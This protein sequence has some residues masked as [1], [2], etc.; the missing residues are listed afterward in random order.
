M[1]QTA[2]RLAAALADRYRLERE[3]GAGGM[4]TVYLAQDLKHDRQVAIK[5]LKPELAAVLGAERFVVEIKTTAALQHPHILPLFDSGTATSHPE[6][7]EGSPAASFLY[8]VMPYIEGETLRD[9]LSRETQLGVDEAVRITTQVADALDYAHR[10]G[11]IHRDIKPENILLHDGRPMVADFGIAL[12]VSAAAGGRMT[13][14]GLSLGTPHYMSPEQA[15][16]DKQITARS[17]IYSLASVL[18]EMLAGEPPHMGNSAQAITMK[19]IAEPAGPVT[20]HRKSV[21]PNVA[22]AIAKAL[23][24]LPA[25]RFDSARQF[26]EALGNT[27]FTAGVGARTRE[28]ATSRAWSRQT[29]VAAVAVVAIVLGAWGWLRPAPT[30][31]VRRYAM[32]LPRDQQLGGWFRRYAISPD[33]STIAYLHSGPGGERQLMVMPRDQLQ[34]TQLA[35]TGGAEVPFFSPDGR[36]IGFISPRG[37]IKVVATTG[38]QVTPIAT[39]GVGYAGATWSRNGYIYAHGLPGHGLVR[40][41]ATGGAVTPFTTIDTAAGETDHIMPVALPRGGGILFVIKHHDLSKSVVA[42]A[43]AES[44]KYRPVTNGHYAEYVQGHLVFQRDRF[45][46]LVIQPFDEGRMTISGEPRVLAPEVTM[47]AVGAP[48]FI[49]EFSVSREG[50]LLYTIGSGVR[51]TTDVV[52]VA[53]D[54]RV[55]PLD[56]T[57]TDQLT[58]NGAFALSP[59]GRRLAV[60]RGGQIWIRDLESR[61]MT[62][63]SFEGG[64]RPVWTPTGDAVAYLSDRTPNLREP[65]MRGADAREPER[66]LL[67]DPRQVHEV[68]FSRDGRW[69]VYRD[70]GGGTSDLL[71]VRRGGDTTRVPLITTPFSE[72]QPALSPDTR[73]L[74]YTTLET[75]RPQVRVRP[76]PNTRDGNWLVSPNG[77]SEPVWAHSGREL[78]YRDGDDNLV[79]VPVTLGPTFVF[80]APRILFSAKQYASSNYRQEYSVAPGDQRLVFHRILNEPAPSRIIVIENV[81][82]IGWRG[83]PGRRVP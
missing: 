3:L 47:G 39:S 13:E 22:G 14:T 15:T 34:A 23:E 25:D 17:D 73:W 5:V 81:T 83:P 80:G 29:A 35:G 43:D 71:A 28:A 55:T 6:R 62:Q 50:T 41:P 20:Q 58:R 10:H 61:R 51:D 54:G 1:T 36:S 78:F 37:T 74:A 21:P 46:A 64:I 72:S 76:F 31:P 63:L 12:A 69:I 65:F 26:A 7:S 67:F 56:P 44:G 57:W 59:D 30:A 66:P 4:A 49:P 70:G 8:Y 42:V 32:Q 38:G 75:G 68:A 2:D 33:G 52:W 27:A 24:K 18:Y 77:G 9:K 19:I 48:D 40:V 79:T 16:A 82:R 11:V 45:G 53:R 60:T